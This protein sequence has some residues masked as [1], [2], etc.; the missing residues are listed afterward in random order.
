MSALRVNGQIVADVTHI[1]I[2][3]DPRDDGP[4]L[5]APMFTIQLDA[6]VDLDTCPECKQPYDG[7]ACAHSEGCALGLWEY[8][9]QEWAAEEAE[10]AAN[11]K[12]AT[13]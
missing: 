8:E 1:Q 2:E 5:V 3:P 9:D 10:R 7:A 4:V 13:A 11:T 6:I 12:G